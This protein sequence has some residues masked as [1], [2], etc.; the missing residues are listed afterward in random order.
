MRIKKFGFIAMLSTLSVVLLFTSNIPPVSAATNYNNLI[1]DSVF[2]NDDTMTA[3][4][5]NA[6]LNAFP[7]SC[8][9]PNSGFAARKPVGYSPS[10]G[11]TYS[12]GYF[13]AGEVVYAA[14]HAYNINPQVLLTTLQKEQSLVAGAE[15]YCNDGDDHKYAAAAGYGCPDGG[16]KYSYSGISLYKRGST[17]HTSVNPTCVNRKEKAGFSQQVIRAAWLLKFSKE[18]SLG[19]TNWAVIKPGW[20]N[21]DD[22]ETCYSG[23]MTQGYRARCPS[24][25]STY[26]SGYATIDGSSVHMDTGAT[27]SLYVYTPHKHGN[28]NFV[29]I[30]T[31]WFG[32]A[33]G[34][35]RL[36][37]CDNSKYLIERGIQTKRLLTDN[38]IIAWE[39]E[40][41]YFQADDRG[42]NYPT[43]PL[44]LDRVVRSR[45][46]NKL[47]LIDNDKAYYVNTQRTA[48]AWS[49]GNIKDSD[50]YPQLDG[51]TIGSNVTLTIAL[52]QLAKSPNTGIT[53]LVDNGQRHAIAGSNTSDDSSLRLIRGYSEVPSAILSVP[54]IQ[55]AVSAPDIDYSFKIGS[56]W[57]LLD[58]GKTKKISGPDAASWAT[59]L[60]GPSLSSDIL[61]LF[62]K[63]TTIDE[64]FRRDPYFYRMNAGSLER[65]S[66]LTVAEE[67][68]VNHSPQITK[69]LKEKLIDDLGVVNITGAGYSTRLISCDGNKYMVERGLQ[70]KRLLSGTAITA[71]GFTN[72]YFHPND[73]G[74]TYPSYAL[75]LESVIRSRNTRREYYVQDGKAYFIHSQEAAD[76]WGLGDVRNQNYPKVYGISIHDNLQT[77]DQLPPP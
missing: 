5:I 66:N 1:D 11:F 10:T 42:C 25:S 35:I 18:R 53:Y 58:H 13:T 75:Q 54:F 28:E 70:M 2:D 73:Y 3:S 24:G 17:V 46:T 52:P 47:Y 64:G 44:P 16:A 49:L 12:S 62:T 43:Y 30:F 67:W 50:G 6:F 65:T 21:S 20:D 38:A 57:Y 72:H 29:A 26:F 55:T 45:D 31:R 60:T 15:N 8:I 48:S 71:W 41:A 61:G 33:S 51:T 40:D 68:E 39:F 74:C 36:I 76:A 14:A 27:A 59:L 77:V 9:S 69:L 19:H 32:S 23:Y 56:S 7:D 63:N 37:S 22:L 4:Q 34:K